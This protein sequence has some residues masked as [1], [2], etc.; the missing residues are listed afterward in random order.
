VGYAYDESGR[1]T[2]LTKVQAPE[3]TGT[4]NG[5]D[6]C[7]SGCPLPRKTTTYRYA[8]ADGCGEAGLLH[9]LTSITDGK[10][11]E[12]LVNQYYASVD[13]RCGFVGPG[14]PV[15]HVRQQIYGGGL[16]SYAYRYLILP[17]DAG[18]EEIAL[19][20]TV[21]D[22]N[23]NIQVHSFNSQG[24]PLSIVTRTN[25]SVRTLAGTDEGDYTV[26]YRYQADG[27]ELIST[28]TE[29]GGITVDRDGNLVAY[30]GGMTVR[31][32]YDQANPDIFQRGNLLSAEDA[33]PERGGQPALYL[34]HMSALPAA[35]GIDAQG[36]DP[37]HLRLP[38]R[39]LCQADVAG[40]RVRSRPGGPGGR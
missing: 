32:N 23:G 26:T 16:V 19:E 17:P 28:R 25:R 27:S 1:P 35:A 2:H 39:D 6:F 12:F 33:G 4:P 29:S 9:N 40:Q 38:G 10:G 31:Y 5:N 37:L 20:T 24:N 18:V 11:Q 22:R 30:P 34:R 13:T 8:S 21:T 3:V 15:D 14:S 7:D 36:H